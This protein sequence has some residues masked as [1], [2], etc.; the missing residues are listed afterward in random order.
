[1][2]VGYG[3]TS[4]EDQDAGL[5]A[6]LRDLTTTG[7]EKLFHEKMS[8]TA[9]ER[10]ALRAA[11]DFVREGDTLVVCKLD[12]LARSVGDL[13]SLV[14]LLEGKQVGLRVLDFGGSP[15]D[16][17]SPSGR[18]LLTMFAAM[19]Q[20]ERE[21]MLERQREGIAAAKAA[22]K[23]KGRKP[24]ARA[25]SSE[26]KR[27]A[28]MGLGATEIAQELKIG[29]ASVYRALKEALRPTASLIRRGLTLPSGG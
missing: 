5:N 7:C 25:K 29:R 10:P 16:T 15:V 19:A 20:F 23:Y 11:L 2:L 4:T 14:N 13:L 6:Q 1:M 26:I 17:K 8:S 27:L 24:T 21:M 9:R 18:L 28:S 3:R 12:R 22:G